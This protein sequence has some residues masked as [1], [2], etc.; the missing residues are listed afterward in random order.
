MSSKIDFDFHLIAELVNIMRTEQQ[1]VWIDGDASD[2]NVNQQPSFSVL[3]SWFVLDMCVVNS[4]FHTK[5]TTSQ[6]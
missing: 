5:L 4:F 2:V 6:N 1:D 3:S